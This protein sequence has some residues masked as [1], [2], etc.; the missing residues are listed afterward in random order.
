MSDPPP[1]QPGMISLE[2]DVQG[3][4]LHFEAI[5][6]RVLEKTSGPAHSPDW[7]ALFAAAD[8]DPAQFRPAEP[9]RT[10]LASADARAAWTGTWPGTTRPLRVEAAAL[11]GKPVAFWLIG[12]WNEPVRADAGDASW[13]EWLVA[14]IF[15]LI[16][17]A[18]PMLAIRNYKQNRGDRRGALRLGIFIFCVEMALWIFRGHFTPALGLLMPMVMAL[19][20]AVFYGVVLWVIYM[21][22]EPYVR[23]RWPQ[24]II[25]WS[26]VLTGQWRNPVVG[27]DVLLGTAL[28][29]AWLLIDRFS[30]LWIGAHGGA[31]NVGNTDFLL[32]LRRSIGVSLMA[33]P[34]SVRSALIFFLLMF[35][36]RVVLRNQWLASAAF[37]GIF[38]AQSVPGSIYPWIDGTVVAINFAIVAMVISRLGLLSLA[39]GVFVNDLLGSL[40][41]TLNISAPYFGVSILEMAI[42]VALCV[43]AL[44]TSIAGH[45][46]WNASFFD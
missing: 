20:S 42:V 12:P 6:P 3:R 28:A 15:I 1:T 7:N 23:R 33:V 13:A 37:V 32:G 10:G 27:R 36:L 44:H 30:A 46:L 29:V 25:S 26:N 43:W 5:P 41:V 40:P 22:I 16:L 35:L 14:A 21:A 9:E 2:T 39:V 8:L 24:A 18:G 45:K 34:G 17:I 19:C 38:I 31:P 4:L 11:R